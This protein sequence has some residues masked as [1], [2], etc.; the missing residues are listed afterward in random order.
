[1]GRSRP[2]AC[3]IATVDPGADTLPFWRRLE[4]WW[5]SLSET[6]EQLGSPCFDENAFIQRKG[7]AANTHFLAH[8][9]IRTRLTHGGCRA[10]DYLLAPMQCIVK[11]QHNS[12][13]ESSAG[14]WKLTL[15]QGV[16]EQQWRRLLQLG[17]EF[18][19]WGWGTSF[20]WKGEATNVAK[21]C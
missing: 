16:A 2:P 4:P 9:V 19:D 17:D 6:G 1:M 5:T 10:G 21:W 18:R 8:K 12:M 3:I 7:R 11:L 15:W 14:C 13:T 20:A